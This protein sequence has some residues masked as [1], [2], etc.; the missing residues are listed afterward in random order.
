MKLHNVKVLGCLLLAL[1]GR[2][3]AEDDEDVEGMVGML[4]IVGS[5]YET[6]C[7]LE[8]TSRHQAI[9]LGALSAG[10]LQRPGD[11]ATRQAFQLR[12]ADCQRTAGGIAS[13]RTGNLTWSAYQPVVSVMF[14]AP[15]DA[16]DPRLVKVQGITGMGLRL[17][18]A[19]GRDVHLGSRGEP[20]FLPLGSNTQ[21]W[22]VQPTRTSAPLTSGA[23]RAVVDFRLNYE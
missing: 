16:D 23:F 18:D 11:Q 21:T 15:A 10:Q 2:A 8:M 17:T 9:D 5:M 4:N 22:Y 6:P 20:L 12:F 13:E 7:S 1:M 19:L 3:H 14:I